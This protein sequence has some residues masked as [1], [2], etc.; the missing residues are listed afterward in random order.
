LD[1]RACF[2]RERPIRS[3]C[4]PR[5]ESAIGRAQAAAR[6]LAVAAGLAV[7]LGGCSNLAQ[8]PA[9][10]FTSNSSP[11]AQPAAAGEASA[12]AA[13]AAGTAQAPRGHAYLLRGLIGDIFS[14]GMDQLAGE[15]NA[16]GIPAR[17]HGV[18][19]WSAVA[20]AA[21]RAHRADG[22]PIILIG[23]STGGDN[24]I[25]MAERLKT[26]NVPV[27]LL[28]TFDPTPIADPVPSNV[29]H[30]LNVY[31]STNPI[32]GGQIRP[33]PG[34]SGHLANVNLRDRREIVHITID[35]SR[36][37]HARVADK[38][39]EVVGAAEAARAA[40]VAAAEPPAKKTAARGAARRPAPA[41]PALSAPAPAAVPIK[42]TVP[43]AGPIVFF[44]SGMEVTVGPQDS[45]DSIAARHGAPTWAIVQINNLNAADGLEVGRRLVVPRNAYRPV[46]AAAPAAAPPRK[47][48]QPRKPPAAGQAARPAQ[49]AAQPA[50]AERSSRIF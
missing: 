27:A 49:Q 6:Y 19:E 38:V 16:R 1:N 5:C 50:P 4:P 29:R 9:L 25:A 11:V 2:C 21:V 23:H 45:L 47:L 22:A 41:P 15:L 32:G 42:Y 14:R 18:F 17:A 35:K 36:T 24:V 39:L 12:L 28:V 40:A 26:A 33:G 8:E 30:A 31:Q 46:L 44:D 10:N 7:L 43:A 37:L 34:F 13:T 48:A 3:H 20:E